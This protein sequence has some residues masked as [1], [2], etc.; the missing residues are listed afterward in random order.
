MFSYQHRIRTYIEL[1][2]IVLFYVVSNLYTCQSQRLPQML[3]IDN[4]NM[5]DHD[6]F[7]V[8]DE[9]V[10]NNN[11]PR[12]LP[13]QS[14]NKSW[15]RESCSKEYGE[16]IFLTLNK[17]AP[18][19][20]LLYSFPGS[21]NTW[22]RQLIEFS[23]GIFSGSIYDDHSLR[24][25]LPAE[26]ECSNRQSVIKAHPNHFHFQQLYEGPFPVGFRD[27]CNR[28]NV[29][30]FTRAI[31]LIRN[32]YDTIWSEFERRHSKSHNSGILKSSFDKSFWYKSLK[33]LTLQ[34]V[35]TWEEDYSYIENV[36]AKADYMYVKYE[37]LRDPLQ[38]ITTLRTIVTF[39]QLSSETV[40]DNRLDCSFKLSENIASHRKINPEIEMTKVEAF[41]EEIVCGMWK[42]LEKHVSPYYSIWN[43]ITCHNSTLDLMNL[44]Y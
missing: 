42:L 38:R 8:L 21:G 25:I 35:T 22:V 2:V 33:Q 26:L 9:D 5:Y 4:N 29:H 43:G 18:A 28:G 24:G 1:F 16:R 11:I 6:S 39:L 15:T 44:R 31:L 12:E 36:L 10:R 41:T 7:P 30:K 27:K 19:P 14:S 34:F 32:P 40:S 37:S 13:D 3:S 23:T 20:P 17:D